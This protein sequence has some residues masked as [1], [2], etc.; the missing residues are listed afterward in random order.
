VRNLFP[1]ILVFALGFGSCQNADDARRALSADLKQLR[2]EMLASADQ[3]DNRDSLWLV[4]SSAQ[5][6][7]LAARFA[8]MPLSN[9]VPVVAKEQQYIKSVLRQLQH[10]LVVSY[11]H[12]MAYDPGPRLRKVLRSTDSP[13][14]KIAKISHILAALPRTLANARQVLAF[15]LQPELVFNSRLRGISTYDLLT[16]LAAK[17]TA[18]TS[19]QTQC[20]AA[21]NAVLAWQDH[22]AWCN[23]R[24]ALALRQP[25]AIKKYPA[26][27]G[28]LVATATL[29]Q[30]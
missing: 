19:T 20:E 16:D 23:S 13:D 30:R 12:P 1:I 9:A 8:K 2:K 21:H 22:L 7:D 18:K 15:D 27:D 6:N 3:L 11:Q 28:V 26:L 17:T 14:Q 29:G 10:Y 5:L 24:A 4:N 25:G